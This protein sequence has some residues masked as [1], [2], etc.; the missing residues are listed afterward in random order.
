V[1]QNKNLYKEEIVQA[2][3]SVVIKEMAA[4]QRV[5]EVAGSRD[6]G[7]A[8]YA[9]VLKV[10][11]D[12][13]L[14]AI[15]K[16]SRIKL[17]I[18]PPTI[19]EEDDIILKE[20]PSEKAEEKAGFLCCLFCCFFPSSSAKS[21]KV[22]AVPTD[23]IPLHE[24]RVRFS[25]LRIASE[26]KQPDNVID[27]DTMLLLI[28]ACACIHNAYEYLK[29][30][31]NKPAKEEELSETLIAVDLKQSL[32]QA[33]SSKQRFSGEAL[34]LHCLNA[35][36]MPVDLDEYYSQRFRSFDEAV[37]LDIIRGVIS[38]SQRNQLFR[39]AVRRLVFGP[40]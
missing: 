9:I 25:E 16:T 7:L 40:T 27:E 35:R 39:H 5:I 21:K 13:L 23:E 19:K 22:A 34:Q 11:R 18:S 14:A 29:S 28:R 12:E 4:F 10:I 6:Q 24:E 32:H 20:L 1:V 8:N 2:R 31:A 36:Q 3:L 30:L 37:R 38:E 15:K 17:T 33:K 26:S